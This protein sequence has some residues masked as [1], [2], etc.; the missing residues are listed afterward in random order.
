MGSQDQTEG[1]RRYRT[2]RLNLG[3]RGNSL[4]VKTHPQANMLVSVIQESMEVARLVSTGDS[5]VSIAES[6]LDIVGLQV[7]VLNLVG[8][9]HLVVSSRQ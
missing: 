9:D 8:Y 5:R 6:N 3:T 2:C 4:D 1:G 7:W